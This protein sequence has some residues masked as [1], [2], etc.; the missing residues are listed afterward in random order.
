M[1]FKIDEAKCSGCRVCQVICSLKHFKE[2]NPKKGA[3]KIHGHFPVPGKYSI[4]VCDQCGVCA[5]VCPESAIDEINGVYMINPDKCT[6]CGICAQECPNDVIIVRDDMD[7]P[8]KCD[9]CG[10]CIMICPRGALIDE[11]GVIK[12]DIWLQPKTLK[13]ESV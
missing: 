5:S 9:N 1:R 4:S 2:V 8:I 7:I 10:E 12:N 3:L 11:E 6:K 13:S